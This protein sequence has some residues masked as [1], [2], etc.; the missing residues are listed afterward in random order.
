MRTPRPH[1]PGLWPK[2]HAA[3]SS[4]ET[5]AEGVLKELL[6][7][8][9]LSEAERKAAATKLHAAGQAKLA[10]LLQVRGGW[11]LVVSAVRCLLARAPAPTLC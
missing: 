2:L 1:P 7:G 8:V 4:A 11:R 3:R 10:S 5:A 9:E 6:S